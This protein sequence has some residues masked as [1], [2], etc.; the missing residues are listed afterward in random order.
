MC[1]QHVLL[2]PCVADDMLCRLSLLR[3]ALGEHGMR[4]STGRRASNRCRG[5]REGM[6]ETI[7]EEGKGRPRARIIPQKARV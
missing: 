2:L 6:I 4:L 1:E 3:N 7:A 5:Q